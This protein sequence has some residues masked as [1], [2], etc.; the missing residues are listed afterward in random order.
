MPPPALDPFQ[1]GLELGR[2]E[3]H[4]VPEQVRQLIEVSQY[5]KIL[6]DPLDLGHKRFFAEDEARRWI[7]RR[8]ESRVAASPTGRPTENGLH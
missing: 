7:E 8:S 4:N 1:Q 3:R 2:T 5:T 6:T